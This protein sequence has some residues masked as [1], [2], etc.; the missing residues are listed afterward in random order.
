VC[1]AEKNVL[2]SEVPRALSH[3]QILLKD[4]KESLRIKGM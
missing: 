2:I 4:S 1:A 3:N